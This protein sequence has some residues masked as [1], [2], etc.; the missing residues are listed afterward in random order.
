VTLNVTFAPAAAGSVTGSVVIV[1]NASNSLTTIPLSGTGVQV[2]SHSVQLNWTASTSTVVGYNVYR[3]GQS[4]GPYTKSNA[5]AV[6][7]ISYTDSVVQSGQTYFYVV[8]AIDSNNLE[9]VY[10]NEV[11]AVIPVP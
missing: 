5:T 9:S 4:G 6:T 3:G 1:S 8:T 7:L 2:V 11:S 10:S